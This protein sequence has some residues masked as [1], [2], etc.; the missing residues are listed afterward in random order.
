[1]L[2][3]EGVGEAEEPDDGGGQK[4]TAATRVWR[5]SQPGFVPSN[6]TRREP[7]MFSD[8]VS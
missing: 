8:A 1:V 2:R 3:L 6:K 7:N 4:K 5:E